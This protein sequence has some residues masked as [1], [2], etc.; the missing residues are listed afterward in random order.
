MTPIQIHETYKSVLSL[1]TDGKLKLAFEKIRLLTDELQEGAFLDRYDDLQQNYRLL[2][3]Y[4]LRGVDDPQRKVIYNKLISRLF[5]LTCELREELLYRNSSNFEY[6]QKRYFPHRL[7]FSST[8]KL[9]DSL[10]YFH[11][12]Q[13]EE[14]IDS[15][16][17]KNYE[18]LLQD[19]FAI[20]W[21]TTSYG[22]NELKLFQKI[23][24]VNYKGRLEKNLA[25]TALTLN[26]WRMFDDEKLQLLLDCC[27]HPDVEVKQRSLVGLCFVLARYNPFIPYFPIIRNRLVLLADDNLTATNFKNIIVQIIGTVETDKITKKLREEILPEVMKISPLLK[28]KMDADSLLKSEEWEEANPEWQEIIE[29]SGVQDKL[30]ELTELQMEGADVYMGTFAMLKNF[31]FFNDFSNWFLPFDSSYSTVSSL[32]DEN[33]QSLL[34]AFV[35]NNALC[36]SDKYSFCMSIMQMPEAQ[37]NTLKRSFKMESDQLAELA[38]D[39]AILSPETYSK[40]ISKQYIQDLFR[41]FKLHPNRSDFSDMFASAL[42]MHRSYLFDILSSGSEL[43]SSVAEFYFAKSQYREAIELFNELLSE[44]DPAAAVFQK[45]G[46]CYQQLSDI[47]SA[48][49]AFL[50][51]DIIQPDDLWTTKK[52]ALCYKV[53]GNF[54]KALEYYKHADFLRPNQQKVLLQLSNCYLELD[55]YKHALEIYAGLELAD[56]NNQKVQ[57][58]VVWCAFISG[59]TAQALYYSQRLLE[60]Q[61]VSTDYIHAAYIA[62]SENKIKE[63]V[64]YLKQAILLTNNDTSLVYNVIVSDLQRMRSA[65]IHLSEFQLIWDGILYQ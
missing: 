54:E 21:L 3:D 57:R 58:A 26:L 34:L 47:K 23:T 7:Q 8:D 43:K 35:G 60:N 12:N 6:L 9:I 1:L 56:E 53:L 17:R 50:K 41:F 39:E 64:E 11:H 36:N 10:T 30:Q 2:L 49:E 55:Q 59:N 40:N 24:N 48:L 13:S 18:R 22:N 16:R 46:Y 28:D 20:V 14:I 15:N 45:I 62:W 25:I 42:F 63:T 37:R 44:N 19:V 38:K 31:S 33:E 52:I 65:G 4:F 51:A 32:F 61:P 29:K 27:S 5:V